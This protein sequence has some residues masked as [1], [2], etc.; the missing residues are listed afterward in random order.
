MKMKWYKNNEQVIA[1][2][3][4]RDEAALEANNMALHACTDT[5][6]ILQNRQRLAEALAVGLDDFVCAEQTHSANFYEV[7][8]ADKGRGA[9]TMSDAIP[10]TDALY[11]AEPNIVL[12]TF[13][14]DCVPVMFSHEKTGIIG[15]IH[16][17]WQGTAKEITRHVFQY[18]IKERN[19]D[20]AYF[21]VQIGMAISQEN[22]EVDRDVQ[23]K[24]AAL[25]Y[26][27]ECMFYRE[28]TGKYHIDNRQVVK[29]Q[30]E[31]VGIPSS[32]IAVDEACTYES[33]DGFS[34]RKD[35]QAGRH[36]G[37]IVKK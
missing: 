21:H 3:T 25:G 27:D 6:E 30:C 23:E 26:A 34:Y 18:L 17:G 10:K 1:G 9:R 13:S 36:L 35:K 29:K 4:L 32:Q 7:T 33:A 37:F 14:A 22:F 20:P 16:S 11:T 19:C 2:I 12:C 31:L 8:S 5:E 28:Q 15:V 24:F